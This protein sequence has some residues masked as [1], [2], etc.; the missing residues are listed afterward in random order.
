MRILRRAVDC[1][2]HATANGSRAIDGTYEAIAGRWAVGVQSMVTDQNDVANRSP[3]W[4]TDGVKPT[5]NLAPPSL[6]GMARVR[7]REEHKRRVSIELNQCCDFRIATWHEP[8]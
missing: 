3:R 6:L 4:F 7:I 8:E 5:N 2:L 1:A